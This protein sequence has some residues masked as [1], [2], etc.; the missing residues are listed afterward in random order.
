MKAYLRKN[1][2]FFLFVLMTIAV[3]WSFAD[4]YRV[5]SGSMEPTIH[6]G[7]HVF[8]NKMAYSVKLPFTNLHMVEVGEPERGD[9][10][11][12][13]SPEP[14]GTNLIK[15]LIALPGDQVKIQNGFI[16]I[17]GIAIEGSESG[18]SILAHAL[19]NEIFYQEH[20]GHADYQVKRLPQYMRNEHLEFTLPKDKFLFMGDNRDNSR[21]GR[22]FGLVSRDL[23]KGKALAVL[24]NI[25][26]DGEEPFM[27]LN[28]IGATL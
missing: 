6:I 7:D 8:V 24:W 22:Y 28:R 27:D 15:R 3:R 14:E 23:L 26:F 10:V 5:P 11:V 4:Q 2:A 25:R 21:D 18:Q 12:F 13:N 9:I 19:A 1:T 17:N 16:W 20:L